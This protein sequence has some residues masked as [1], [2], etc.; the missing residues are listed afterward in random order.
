[1]RGVDAPWLFEARTLAGVRSRLVAGQRA[2]FA[3]QE[4]L[5]AFVYG[6]NR[7][8]T[9]PDWLRVCS[10]SIRKPISGSL[11]PLLHAP[12]VP[13]VEVILACDGVLYGPQIEDQTVQ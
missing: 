1:L 8:S 6:S 2:H 7:T 13:L 3:T 5:K 12:L 9:V 4:H 10:F 11:G